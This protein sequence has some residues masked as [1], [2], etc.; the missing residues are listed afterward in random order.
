MGT[1]QVDA[2]TQFLEFMADEPVLR[3]RSKPERS[4]VVLG[5]CPLVPLNNT[6]VGAYVRGRK[7]W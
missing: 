6:S 4:A 3:P 5:S 2:T 1:D 7:L